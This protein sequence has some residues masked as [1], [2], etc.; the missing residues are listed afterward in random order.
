[1]I[2]EKFILNLTNSLKKK[3]ITLLSNTLINFPYYPLNDS[4][5]YLVCLGFNKIKNF[6]KSNQL[7]AEKIDSIREFSLKRKLIRLEI[8]NYFFLQNLKE[9]RY[10]ILQSLDYGFDPEI[11]RIFYLT[12]KNIEDYKFFLA[13]TKKVI[14]SQD[15]NL[16]ECAVLI[17]FLKENKEYE[18]LALLLAILYKK[19]KSNV[20]LLTSIAKNYFILRKY[21]LSKIYYEKLIIC[22]SDQ[23]FLIDL[24]IVCNYL[25]KFE[26]SKHYISQCLKKDPANLRAIVFAEGIGAKNNLKEDSNILAFLNKKNIDTKDKAS[27]HFTMG[28]RYESEKDYKSALEHFDEANKLKNLHINFDILKVKNEGDFFLKNFN[29]I[30]IKNNKFSNE[31]N[32][33]PIFIVGLPRSGTTL[34]EHVLGS[35]NK[36][37]HFGETINFFRNFKFLFNI[38]DLEKNE[39]LFSSYTDADYLNYGKLYLEYFPLKKNKS[40]FTDKMPFNF[41]YLGLIK[42]TLPQSKIIICSRDYRDVGLSIYKNDFALDVNFAYKKENIIDY[43][44]I[45]NSIICEW[46]NMLGDNIFEINYEKLIYDPHKEVSAMLS[47]CELDFDQA[48]LEFYKKK[49]STDTLSASQV[50]NDFYDKSIKSWKNFYPYDNTFFDLLSEIK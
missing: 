25:R 21:N 27:L 22:S 31:H 26:V 2:K 10:K 20:Y 14:L 11:I 45:Y 47:Y 3:N 23:E 1:M 12:C 50:T 41:F 46:K 8:F 17:N 44:K 30:E 43:I 7:I 24:A 4:E 35:H 33:T 40:Y 9:C 18:I 49:L 34:V 16:K 5:Y 37:Q 36:V 13:T 6:L 32:K 42:R 15:L 48:C 29:R 38:Y 28:Q 39:K 19:D